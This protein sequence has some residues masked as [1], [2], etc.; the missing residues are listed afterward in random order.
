MAITK[1]YKGDVERS[2]ID[3]IYKGTTLL[4]E[5][6]ATPIATASGTTVS[7]DEVE[8]ATSYEILV[9]GSS[10]GTVS[11][12]SV[13][14]STLSGW[15]SLIDG[16]YSVTIVAKADG[17]S[18]SEP[19]TAVSVDVVPTYTIT[20]ELTN[21]TGDSSNPTTIQGGS[22]ATLHFTA[23]SGYQ[24]PDSVTVTGA[25]SSWN[26]TTGTLTLSNPTDNVS[27]S[28]VGEP[29]VIY[30]QQKF[31]SHLGGKGTRFYYREYLSGSEFSTLTVTLTSYLDLKANT[32]Y[33]IY[34]Y[35]IR[36][37]EY[38]TTMTSQGYVKLSTN[39]AS[40]TELTDR[41]ANISDCDNSGSKQTHYYF[42]LV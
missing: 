41:N 14:L 24:L 23:N 27:F 13:D 7:W 38:Y 34:S 15:S 21:V 39:P 28:V 37:K 17:Y 32:T 40:P 12:T 25:T 2:D 20:P 42:K 33:E 30:I 4:Y 9:G 10:F 16:S 19:S 31:E 18:D 29:A 11:T 35:S 8:N 3:K 1:I 22:T 26:K 5:K 6:L 36:W